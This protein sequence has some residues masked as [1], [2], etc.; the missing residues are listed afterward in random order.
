[1]KAEHEEEEINEAWSSCG[2]EENTDVG[3]TGF[4]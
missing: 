2:E 1:M 4:Q 3:A